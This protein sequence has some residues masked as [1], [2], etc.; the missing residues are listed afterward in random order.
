[1]SF[2]NAGSS[3]S[4]VGTSTQNANTA[5]DIEVIDPPPDSISS[6][7][8]SPQGDFLA[9]GSWDNNVRIYEVGANGQSQV[10]NYAGG[11]G[12]Y[13]VELN[14]GESHVWA[15]RTNYECLLEQGTWLY[16][17]LFVSVL[18]WRHRMAPKFSLVALTRQ[19]AC[20]MSS[21][22]NPARSLHT[23]LLSKPLNG[24]MRRVEFLRLVVGIKP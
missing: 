19:L 6:L 18:I 16:L 17:H 12:R 22:D 10:R 9:A 3:S 21:R 14:L 8:W 13:M 20:S 11:G 23:M 2:F 5:K 24:L 7:S 4:V 15:R 1:M